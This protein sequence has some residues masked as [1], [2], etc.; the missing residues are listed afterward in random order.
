MKLP[1]GI[2]NCEQNCLTD[3]VITGSFEKHPHADGKGSR[4]QSF[5]SVVM[6]MKKKGWV[7][8]INFWQ[9]SL[10]ERVNFLSTLFILKKNISNFNWHAIFWNIVT[11]SLLCT[12][13]LKSLPLLKYQIKNDMIINKRRW[14]THNLW[15]IFEAYLKITVPQNLVVCSLWD[16]QIWNEYFLVGF[17]AFLRRIQR[18][19]HDLMLIIDWNEVKW[20]IPMIVLAASMGK[21]FIGIKSKLIKLKYY[22]LFFTEIV[23]NYI[24]TVRHAWLQ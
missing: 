10:F 3:P 17:F 2:E 24:A 12:C 11:F 21:A 4:Q 8:W 14:E 18:Q 13:H 22:R 1:S 20:I 16:R 23:V 7:F 9:N 19:Q 5:V 15:A 6:D